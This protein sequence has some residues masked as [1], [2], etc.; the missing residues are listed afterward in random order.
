MTSNRY[1]VLELLVVLCV[2]HSIMCITVL[3]PVF[4]HR[5]VES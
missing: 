2:I 4:F 3:H 1:D 5:V